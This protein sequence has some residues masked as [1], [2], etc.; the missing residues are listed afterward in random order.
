MILPKKK[1]SVNC[2]KEI[3]LQANCGSILT[4]WAK[5]SSLL[6]LPLFFDGPFAKAS[7]AVPCLA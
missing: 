7:C 6:A 2:L 3:G 1:Q 5:D 4:L